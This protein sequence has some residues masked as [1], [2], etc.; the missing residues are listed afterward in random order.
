MP[1]K[2]VPATQAKASTS[3]CTARPVWQDRIC[4]AFNIC[5][6]PL[7]P[8]VHAR[9]HY[10]VTASPSIEGL[11]LFLFQTGYEY[12]HS[13]NR[14]SCTAKTKGIFWPHYKP[15]QLYIMQNKTTRYYNGM[16]TTGIKPLWQSW[17]Y[18]KF[19]QAHSILRGCCPDYCMGLYSNCTSR[20]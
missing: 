6:A 10:N 5:R 9:T 17:E 4:C 8:R 3:F 1:D 13:R 16:Y 19:V 7:I 2:V 12:W 18:S 11:Q 15:S 14:F 20:I